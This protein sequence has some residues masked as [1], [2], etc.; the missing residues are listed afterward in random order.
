MYNVS[1]VSL[2]SIYARPAA[3][4]YLQ[5]DSDNFYAILA[6]KAKV[7]ADKPAEYE[8]GAMD[9][10]DCDLYERVNNDDTAE[11]IIDNLA[12]AGILESEDDEEE[13]S[14]AVD[15]FLRAIK[16]RLEARKEEMTNKKKT[17]FTVEEV[18]EALAG[19]HGVS[20]FAVK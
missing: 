14:E 12:A 19:L 9:I 20:G 8:L 4:K 16:E 7:S 11:R 13:E 2:Q 6:E 15:E 10:F 5:A 1:S 17:G 3:E 18:E